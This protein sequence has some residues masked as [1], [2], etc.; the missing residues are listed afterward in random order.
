MMEYQDEQNDLQPDFQELVEAIRT[1]MPPEGQWLDAQQEFLTKLEARRQKQT[2]PRTILSGMIQTFFPVKARWA[3]LAASCVLI[4]VLILNIASREGGSGKAYAAMTIKIHGARTMICKVVAQSAGQPPAQY[5]QA[6][7]EPC[8]TRTTDSSGQAVIMDNSK[9][10]ALIIKPGQTSAVEIDLTSMPTGRWQL[11][12]VDLLR[13]L[14]EEVDEALGKKQLDGRTVQGFRVIKRGDGYKF[15]DDIWIDAR[16]DELVRMEIV[17]GMD[18]GS[19]TILSDFQFDV[20]LDKSLFSTD[21]PK[22]FKGK[23]TYL[24]TET[25]KPT[26]G[27]FI[28]FLI[29]SVET[30]SLDGCFPPAVNIEDFS[31]AMKEANAKKA[32][33]AAKGRTVKSMTP[34]ERDAWYK[35][36]EKKYKESE[37][38]RK[39]TEERIK[40]VRP[41]RKNSERGG[42][43]MV[44]GM[45]FASTMKPENDFHYAGKGVQL[46]DAKTPIAWWKPDGAQTYRVIHGDLSIRDVAAKDRPVAK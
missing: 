4:A 15:T 16:T 39:R 22:D 26:E 19:R 14:P 7:M 45:R 1:D 34:A 23:R 29:Q 36:L 43:A 10:K 11:I 38:N 27:D 13:S 40:K 12:L 35:S 42:M 24:N 31:R 6:Y 17:N 25:P 28:D 44:Q 30:F 9:K 37:E 21:L 20:N 8:F 32:D 5:T 3:I 41:T 18:G 46:G 2:R 33:E